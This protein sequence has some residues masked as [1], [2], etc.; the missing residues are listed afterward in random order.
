M[1]PSPRPTRLARPARLI[2]AAALA[3][4]G[5]PAQALVTVWDGSSGLLPE[6]VDPGWELIDN[7]PTNPSLAGG[8]LTIQT[9][10]S[11]SHQQYYRMAGAAFAAP[12]TGPYWLEAE[13]R[14]VSGS[15]TSGWWRAPIAMG[16]RFDNGRLAVLEIRP[17]FIYIRN[18][19]NSVGASNATVDTN[20]AFHT[21]RMEVLG[22]ASG[23]TVNVYQNGLLVLTDN[24][25]YNASGTAGVFFGES[26][27]LAL[28]TSEW[29][30]VSHNMAAVATPIPEPGSYA[31][32]A[33]GLLAIGARAGRLRAG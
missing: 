26:S 25:V 32:M 30:R 29:K 27:T 13:V 11:F 28:G 9:A 18:G 8:V 31:L 2:A 6:Q 16:I 23:S 7:A 20:D 4:A 3:A 12:D 19:D 10:G 33:L 1:T 5:L 17:D 21:Y 14:L 24:A 22:T 15:Q